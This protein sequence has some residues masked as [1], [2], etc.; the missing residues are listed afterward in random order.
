M[1]V[2][3]QGTTILPSFDSHVLWSYGSGNPG[4]GDGELSGPHTADEN[5]IDPDE[6]I[7]AEQYG[8]DIL[9][10]NRSTREMRCLYGERGVAG[11]GKRLSGA[12]SAHVMPSGPYRGHVL[13]TEYGGEHRVMILH[14]D[15]GNILWCYTD[16]EAPLEAIYWDDEHIM[17]SDR[18]H[19]VFKIRLG[20]STKRWQ[21]D[22]QPRCR[23][24]Y[25]QKLF[26]QFCDSY[27]GDLLI[28]YW[29]GNAV[30]REINTE[31][32]ETVWL[33]G[34]N[35]QGAGDLYNHL[36]CPA[37]AFRYGTNERGG[38]LT[39]IVDE[40]TRIF[41]LNQAK[42]LIW[43]LG[44]ASGEDRYIATQYGMSP[45][46]INT[47]RRGNLL[48]TDW[49]RNMIYE[50]NPFTIPPRMEKDAY[51]FREYVTTDGYVDSGIMESRG[52]C[53]KNLQIFNT[54][55]F[56]SLDWQLL[57]SRNAQSWQLIHQPS[58]PLGPNQDAFLVVDGMWNY[59]MTKAKSTATG[60][61]AIVD[62]FLTM[63][64]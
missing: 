60:K 33:Y 62:I 10:I 5:P 25:L 44:G 1:N 39:V 29:G 47:T 56:A 48:I 43:E 21:F 46:Y 30:V 63:R 64:R 55:A 19:G 8:N 57:G 4:V 50:V 2:S 17:A 35:Q 51:L 15:S 42:E 3:V 45:T 28:G 59:L 34:D 27:G 20:D 9:V 61:P 52:Y 18:D 23:P 16:L 37:R 49:G 24:F 13:I 41:C 6:I 58:E 22:P 7:V 36:Y 38:G 14:R 54:D 12:H 31:T 53:H 40:K 32:D 26:P 11:T